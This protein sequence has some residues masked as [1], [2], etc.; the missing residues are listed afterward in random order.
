MKKEISVLILIATFLV[1]NNAFAQAI[2]AAPAY[3]EYFPEWEKAAEMKKQ[4]EAIPNID[5]DSKA[6]LEEIFAQ[7]QLKHD[8]YFA[9]TNP[10]LKELKECQ[11]QL[12]DYNMDVREQKKQAAPIVA[13]IEATPEDARTEEWVNSINQRSLPLKEWEKRIAERKARLDEWK[14]SLYS[15]LDQMYKD[16][17]INGYEFKEWKS[18]LQQFS[19]VL[20]AAENGQATKEDVNNLLYL[21]ILDKAK[22]AKDTRDFKTAAE[23][24]VEV[25]QINP[26][27]EDVQKRLSELI[28]GDV[29]SVSPA[30]ESTPQP[31]EDSKDPVK[32]GWST[33]TRLRE[34]E[35]HSWLSVGLKNEL[36]SVEARKGWDT[37]TE[38]R[39]EEEP[40]HK[41][42]GIPKEIQ[43]P[44]VPSELHSEK[45][46]FMEEKRTE[47]RQK[48]FDMEKEL[49]ELENAETKDVVMIA[50]TKQE[51]STAK[52]EEIFYNFSIKEEL[53]T[54]RPI[55]KEG[56]KQ[57]NAQ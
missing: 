1:F 38:I 39:F 51:I 27:N 21:I 42:K 25:E 41:Y 24:V 52:S 33:Y 56:E 22:I 10:L 57:K 15:R 9:G 46:K 34:I 20:I 44:T 36:A 5:E 50:E 43:D 3:S 12:H 53:R 29:A 45:I 4:L 7:L 28:Y 30:S 32:G 23:L 37:P 48:R 18:R 19:Q 47:V 16:W 40:L 31:Q 54:A 35:E 26:D 11:K 13:E 17:E 14:A 49:E 2:T 55:E 8:V 6:K